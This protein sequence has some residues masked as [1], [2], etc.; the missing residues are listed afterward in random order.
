MHSSVMLRHTARRSF[1]IS[2]R[3]AS[4][5]TPGSLSSKL[6]NV[7]TAGS[8]ANNNEGAASSNSS[9]A[10]QPRQTFQG[11]K[12]TS[13]LLVNLRKIKSTR[14]PAKI[15]EKHITAATSTAG[16]DGKAATAKP[17]AK[18]SPPPVK[19]ISE[20]EKR[21][22]A[23]F[24]AA[25]TAAGH[26]WAKVS[27]SPE[28][29]SKEKSIEQSGK[30][31]NASQNESALD[32]RLKERASLLNAARKGVPVQMMRVDAIDLES[33]FAIPSLRDLM[34]DAR[35]KSEKD[36]ASDSTQV[37]RQDAQEK[38]GGDYSRYMASTLPTLAPEAATTLSRNVTYSI[39]QR[40][41]LASAIHQLSSR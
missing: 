41:T 15:I 5:M 9:T 23:A 4:E 13:N 34:A 8:A 32:G 29:S 25:M 27:K 3:V 39:P 10:S 16:K 17:E 11:S 31:K 2:A 30:S 37:A 21:E 1:T 22:M 38:Y 7:R 6:L 12:A 35:V 40:G 24:Q 18:A 36:T 20:E 14:N 33:P 26:K 19:P 28:S